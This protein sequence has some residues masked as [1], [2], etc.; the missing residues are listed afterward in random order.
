MTVTILEELGSLKI[1]GISRFFV[2]CRCDKCDS[3]F[4]ARKDH[5]VR[6]KNPVL[7]CGCNQWPTGRKANNAKPEGVA[8]AKSVYN[9]YKNKCKRKG[10]LF[11]I[12]FKDFIK[13]TSSNCY[14][15]DSPPRHSYS[16]TFKRGIRA[17]LKKVNGTYKYNGIDRIDSNGGYTKDNMNPCCRY[18]NF[19]KLDR[20][21]EDFYLW[22]EKLYNN[23]KENNK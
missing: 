16:E 18:C 14:Y 3:E 1:S 6:K 2:R 8:S 13:I 23:I 7:S 22:V 11:D 5:V 4:T 9:S 15:C 10:I 17:G 21:K 20:T 19:A 12:T